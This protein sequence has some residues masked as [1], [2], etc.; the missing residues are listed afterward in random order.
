M[1]VKVRD[2]MRARVVTVQPHHSVGHVRD[3]LKRNRIHAVPVVD[4]EG[5]LV[6]IVSTT[7]LVAGTKDGPRRA[8]S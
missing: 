6:G 8:R 4:G 2:L 1:N 5:R 3:L 7:D